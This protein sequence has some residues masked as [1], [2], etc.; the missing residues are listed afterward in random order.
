MPGIANLLFPLLGSP[1]PSRQLAAAL[2]GQQQ[3][4]AQPPP[5]AAPPGVTPPPPGGT[6]AAG[7]GDG[8][9]PAPPPATP[10]APPPPGSAPQPTVLQ[11]SPDMS[12]SYQQLAQPNLMN[13]YLQLQQRDQAMQGF[14]SG[15]ALIAANHSPPSMRQAIMQSANA[16]AGDAG[17]TVNNLMSLYGAQ[18]QMGAQQQLLAHADEYDQKLGLPPGTARAEI[19]AGRGPDLIKSLEPT[20]E[21]R[22]YQQAR[23]L[24]QQ[25]NPNATPAEIEE[26]AQAILMGGGGGGGDSATRS[27]RSAKIQWDANPSTKG[28]PYPW[29]VGAD[30]NPTS[31][32]SWQGAQKSAETKQADDQQDASRLGPQYRANLQGARD[33]VAGIL[34]I[35]P[36][37]NIDPA[38]EAQ[39]KNLL[40]TD[41]AQK[42]VNSDPTK[43]TWGQDLATW[44]GNL[45]PEDQ[46]LLTQIRDAT[47]E[48]TQLGSLKN[49]APR[50]GQSDASDIGVGLG[51]MRNVTQGYDDWITGAKNTLKAIDTATINSFGAQ[52]T[53][54]A[55]EDYAR[56]H[57]LPVDE[58]LPLMDDNYVQG[59]SMFPKGKFAGTMSQPQIAAATTAIK[60]AADPEAERQKQI[61]LALVRNT[62]PT[63]LKNLRL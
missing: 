23:A 10:G 26:A 32:A 38:R 7:P 28:T 35:Q 57:N 17:T 36:D 13:L 24:A 12:A 20:T 52:G 44:W 34:G 47:D 56:K 3:P 22:N 31:F 15:L 53:P 60:G 21:I 42:Y 4:G 9:A 48:K 54:E 59:G 37:G 25:Q 19:M 41:M 33:R 39:L 40:G 11:S 49:R 30:D 63:P 27:W 14:N 5:G 50:R 45:Q 8:S 6:A 18:N 51:G 1:D 58:A 29:G 55:A 62:D 61:K 16:G 46:T 2:A 43:E